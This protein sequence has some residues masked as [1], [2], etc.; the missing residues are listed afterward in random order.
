MKR[1]T[2]ILMGLFVSGLLA[3]VAFFILMRMSEQPRKHN[4]LSVGGEPVEMN[5]NG[6]RFVKTVVCRPDTK[7]HIYMDGEVRLA[8]S[9]AVGERKVVYPKSEYLK[10]NRTNDTLLITFD[11][12]AVDIPEDTHTWGYM[13]VNGVDMQ[14]YADSLVGLHCQAND[15]LRLKL[16]NMELDSLSVSASEG[17]WLDSCRFRSLAVERVTRFVAKNSRIANLRLNLDGINR[18]SVKNC[19]IDTEYLRGSGNRHNDLQV[20]EC[21][22][23]VWTPTAEDARLQVTL[24]ENAEVILNPQ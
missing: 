4:S 10:V 13:S 17:V 6:I 21:R 22:R 5:M 12:T 7:V 2:Y 20:G 14:I 3:I 23:V 1:T 24:H 18:W 16:K 19:E 8:P 11:F 15:G 9:A